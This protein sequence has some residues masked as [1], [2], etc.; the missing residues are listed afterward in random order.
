[1]KKLVVASLAAAAMLATSAFQAPAIFP[2]PIA[3]ALPT[4][5][6]ATSAG[7]LNSNFTTGDLLVGAPTN[8]DFSSGLTGWTVT[9]NANNVS[10]AAGGPAGDY[11]HIVGSG[12]VYVASSPF[13]VSSGGTRLTYWVRTGSTALIQIATAPS[14]TNWTSAGGASTGGAW[15]EISADLAS[16][17]GQSIK[18]RYRI[19]GAADFDE[20]AWRD[21]TPNWTPGAGDITW[22][23]AVT[24]PATTSSLGDTTHC[25]GAGV[26]AVTGPAVTLSANQTMTSMPFTFPGDATRMSFW[27]TGSGSGPGANINFTMLDENPQVER[28]L[29]SKGFNAGQS[30]YTTCDVSAYAGRPAKIKFQGGFGKL[31]IAGG[32]DALSF[33]RS[34]HL[35]PAGDPVSLVSGAN[36]HSHTDVAIP[37]RAFRSS[38]RESM[39]PARR[40][41]RAISA[42]D[43]RTTTARSLSR[44]AMDRHCCIDPTARA[45]SSR[46]T[47][48]PSPRPR[49]SSTRS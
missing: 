47:Q 22:S 34:L 7:P 30:I 15:R 33:F 44:S 27:M 17:L 28:N 23:P 12:L 14:Y 26:G 2:P 19:H 1:M 29:F 42:G 13:T 45:C 3:H 20:G 25:R 16:Y 8:Y 9:G 46:T 37:G 36:I 38:S 43:G 32:G 5:S 39:S 48:V 11:L 49:A 6:G 31:T 41:L 4:P 18:L 35:D 10:T 40:P 21:V 24:I